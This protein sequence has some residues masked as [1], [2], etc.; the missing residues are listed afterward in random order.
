MCTHASLSLMSQVTVLLPRA[1][2]YSPSVS[3]MLTGGLALL[4][5]ASGGRALA[6]A[7][8]GVARL[9]GRGDR[10]VFTLIVLARVGRGLLALLGQASFGLEVGLGRGRG[11]RS[12][13]TFGA[14]RE[15]RRGLRIAA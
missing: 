15:A 6:I 7:L 1:V 2:M 9:V 8:L 5:F 11:G 12:D 13:V 3:S 4:G 14:Q 10:R